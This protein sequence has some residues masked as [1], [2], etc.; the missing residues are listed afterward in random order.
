MGVNSIRVPMTQ[1]G[2]GLHMDSD[3]E[4]FG[5]DLRAVLAGGPS[6]ADSRYASHHRNH[7]GQPI[8][9]RPCLT[10]CSSPTP[11]IRAEQIPHDARNQATF[12]TSSGL[13]FY[14]VRPARM[15]DPLHRMTR[16]RRAGTATADVLTAASSRP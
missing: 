1:T 13:L 11:A 6:S 16:S 8:H 10:T 9:D 14:V 2:H 12:Q 15:V 4:T 5:N 3:V 7:L